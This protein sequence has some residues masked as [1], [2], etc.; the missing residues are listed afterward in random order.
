MS[1]TETDYRN[2]YW[3]QVNKRKEI[4]DERC[5]D[6]S[7][8]IREVNNLG[9]KNKELM[10][11]I[12]VLEKK[13]MFGEIVRKNS[14]FYIIGCDMGEFSIHKSKLNEIEFS[15]EYIGERFSFNIYYTQNKYNIKNLVLI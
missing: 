8:L 6:K 15:E 2:M 12:S 7:S 1:T 9:I 4:E 14:S 11:R 10:N 5:F 13:K 3:S